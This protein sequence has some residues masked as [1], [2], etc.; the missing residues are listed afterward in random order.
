MC[1]SLFQNKLYRINQAH[2][3]VY[4]RVFMSNLVELSNKPTT[5]FLLQCIECIPNLNETLWIYQTNG[6]NSSQQIQKIKVVFSHSKVSLFVWCLYLSTEIEVYFLL[7]IAANEYVREY[8]EHIIPHWW[9]RWEKWKKGKYQILIW[10]SDLRCFL[11]K[12]NLIILKFSETVEL[13]TQKI[14]VRMQ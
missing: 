10:Q 9:G 6:K 5:Y 13:L 8:K 14:N 3:E 1:A 7:T 2:F 12:N 11:F 4:S